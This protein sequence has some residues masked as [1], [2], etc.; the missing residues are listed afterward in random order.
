M[1]SPLRR[2]HLTTVRGRNMLARILASV[3]G[4]GLLLAGGA[5]HAQQSYGY[6]GGSDRLVPAAPHSSSQDRVFFFSK[7]VGAP[8][9]TS[10]ATAP[11]NWQRAQCEQASPYSMVPM[12]PVP[13]P[14]TAPA[15]A[16]VPMV[17]SALQ[18]AAFQ[19][20]PGMAP[21]TGAELSPE[22]Y[23]IQLEP[24]DEE[25][26]FRPLDSDKDLQQRIRQEYLSRRPRERVSFP[27]GSVLAQ[28]PY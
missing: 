10:T 24:P 14:Q 3:C 15:K 26:L 18:R 13:A 12:R 28:D 5:A 20:P 9:P 1:I 25:R 27:E 11:P 2:K 17:D 23:S 19:Q 16:R 21:G 6:T 4:L 8:R 7:D 22:E